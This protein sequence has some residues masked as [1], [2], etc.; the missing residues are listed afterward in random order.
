MKK[1]YIL[2]IVFVG[3]LLFKSDIYANTS[4][5]TK[6]KSMKVYEKYDLSEIITSDSKNLKYTSSNEDVAT[7]SDDGIVFSKKMGEFLITVA[8]ENSSSTCKFSSGY[9]VGIDVSTFNSKVEWNKVK[10]QGID[11][12][13]IRS[14]YGWYDEVADKDEEY[15]FQYD[16]EFLNN[17]KGVCDNNISFG[18]YHFSYARNKEEAELEAEY[19]LNAIN[20]YG[21]EYKNE[22]SLPIA[23][24]VEYVKDLT[25]KELTDVVIAFCSKI[26][27]AGYTPMVYSNNNFFANY[28]DLAKLN[29]FAYKYWY[30]APKKEPDFSERI[31][32]ADTQTS[33]FMW[34]YTFEGS[35]E[36]AN[37]DK[38]IVDM[39]IMY[40]KDRV[41][42]EIRDNGQVIDIIGADKG[43]K[44][45]KIPA[46]EKNGYKFKEIKDEENNTIDENYIFNKDTIATAVFEKI[47]ITQIALDKTSIEVSDKREHYI[48][49]K[50]FLPVEATL[51]GE[52]VIF[53]S[54][55]IQIATVDNTG[56]IIPKKDGECTITCSLESNRSI[57]ASCK[58]NV[59]FGYI[60]GDLDKNKVIN[61]NDAAIALDLYKNGNVTAENLKIGDMDNNRVINA[62]DAAII[63]DLY[64]NGK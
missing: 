9:F 46:Y 48:K 47:K 40:M 2:V 8:D 16:K 37:T 45:D 43:G 28:L 21:S 19:V 13:M 34:Q 31:T 25:K 49:V 57:K 61:A 35:V 59:H 27:E 64:K 24:D 53:T 12:A 26:Y 4:F 18:I 54:D 33:P 55:D 3:I 51:D 23:Y 20:N 7:V 22:M 41:K 32:I 60:K 6:R 56:R 38:G 50:S 14:S 5:N 15:D 62:N 10:E 29:A 36:G 30:S 58:V 42:V 39:N 63:L 52:N 1:Y 44:I 17:L 11:F